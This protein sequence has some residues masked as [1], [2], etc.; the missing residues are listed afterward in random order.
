MDRHHSTSGNE[1]GAYLDLDDATRIV[2]RHVDP[3][4]KV[5]SIRKLYGG[6]INRVLEWVLDKPDTSI[7][8]K[9][10]HRKSAKHFRKEMASLQIFA[11]RTGLPVPLPIACVA[12]EPGFD[13]SGLLMEKIDGVPLSDAKVSPTGM[14]HLERELAAHVT[15]LHGH[16]RGTYGNAVRETGGTQR[17]LDIFEP[18]IRGE[19][20]HVRPQLSS[21]ARWIIDDILG[22]LEAWLPEGATP[23]LVHGDLW[24]NNILVSD[25]HPD[26]PTTRAFI[27]G[28][29]S[30]ADPEYEL[31][32]LRIFNTVGD[33]FF[34]LYRQRHPLRAGFGRRCRVYWLNTM[35]L[36]A[37]TFGERYLPACEDLAMQ[38]KQLK[39]TR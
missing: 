4:L 13:G 27:D 11:E 3:G 17:W 12:D 33:E 15:E 39:N 1:R 14:R 9:L 24:A 21:Q 18:M 7:V 37:R 5:V 29:A 28:N 10:N 23:T 35:M 16:H 30:Y 8:A 26:R 2:Q 19:Y 31:A 36:H 22:H 6:S 32:Y 38:L 20:D 25:A 34:R